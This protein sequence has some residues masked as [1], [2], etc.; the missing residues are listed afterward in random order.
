M[1][2]S[3]YQP[4]R[5]VLYVAGPY[6]SDPVGNTRVA[7]TLFHELFDMGYAPIIPH[8]SLFLDFV[9]PRTWEDWMVLDLPIVS[10]CDAVFRMLGE[11]KGADMEVAF[12]KS[13]GTPVLYTREELRAF[14][15]HRDEA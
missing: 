8:L 5:P 1:T 11:S 15:L 12:A 9:K 3:L 14:L 13:I 6:T 7:C 4:S 10:K 2:N